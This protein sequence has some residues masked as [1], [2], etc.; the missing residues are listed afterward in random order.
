MADVDIFFFKAAPPEQ[1]AANSID[2]L[3][4]QFRNHRANDWSIQEA[5]MCLILSAAVCDGS[6]TPEEDAEVRALALRTRTL[7]S[8]DPAKLAA[9]NQTVKQRLGSRPEG[10]REA[11]EALPAD[12]RL[13]VFA[14]CVDVC[15]A[16][17]IM[18]KAETDFL[19]NI[20][21]HMQ[22]TRE[23]ATNVLQVILTKNRF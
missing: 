22:L 18:M 15:L 23:D 4:D 16:D 10:V 20:S 1:V 17:G 5:F 19:N 12:M 7:K 9:V 6:F 8:L 3:L 13:A 14:H 2:S 11:C 21:R